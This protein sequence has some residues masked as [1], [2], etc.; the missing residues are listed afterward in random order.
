MKQ[1]TQIDLVR[2]V[3]A[4]LD[5][6]TTDCGEPHS[7]PVGAYISPDR[8]AAELAMFRRGPIWIGHC[9]EVAGAG[10]FITRDV[11]GTPV[12]VV[13]QDDGTIAGFVNVCRHR[14]TCVVGDERG[15]GRKSFVCPYHGWTYGRSGELVGVPDRYGFPSV[16]EG[17]A[18]LA[19]CEVGGFIT[20]GPVEL[21]PAIA[22]DLAS[23]GLAGHHVYAPRRTS[24]ELNWKLT[25][26]IFLESYHLRVAHRDTIYPMFFDNVGLVDPFEPHMRNV[27][28][29][30][31]I[32]GLRET[33]PQSWS[34]RAHANI[35]Y[36]LFPNTIVL[37]EP[38][39]AA[40][41]HVF[42]DGIDRCAI[43]S[44]T[45]VPEAPTEKAARYW[46]KNN[47]ILYTAIAEDFELG[48]SI[49]AGFASGANEALSFAAYEHAL[50]YFHRWV[51]SRIGAPEGAPIVELR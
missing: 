44:Y 3:H 28:P 38:D 7:Q 16:P 20:T 2:R 40:V 6:R 25:F 19:L 4:H 5:A 18:P 27:F 51:E 33:D 43:S 30:R 14:G 37:I 15:R 46:D 9:S 26:D 35:L 29:K 50:A 23:Y 49:Q 8:Y 24:R 42:P 17:L 21:H 13:R 31:T 12:L 41:L 10:D 47:E 32:R 45:L 1:Q 39:H 22:D 36:F 48:A 34:L 11:G